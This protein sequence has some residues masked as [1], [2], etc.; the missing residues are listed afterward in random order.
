MTIEELRVRPVSWRQPAH[1][2][3][4]ADQIERLVDEFYGRVRAD[5]RLG[6]I[7]DSRIQSDD[8]QVHLSKMKSFWRSVLLRTGEYHGKPVPAHAQLSDVV[9]DDFRI[10]LALFRKTAAEIFAPEPMAVVVETAER[11]ASSLWLAMNAHTIAAP[12]D[13]TSTASSPS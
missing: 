13:W 9:T 11:I 3:I 4:S 2:N 8:W 12:P 5:S 1:P 7:F 6:P 10:W